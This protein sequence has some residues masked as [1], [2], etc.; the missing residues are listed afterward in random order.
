MKSSLVLFVIAVLLSSSLL[1]Q[2]EANMFNINY[3]FKKATKPAVD[4]VKKVVK[5]NPA[6][7]KAVDIIEE[8]Y[9]KV[10]S[11]EWSLKEK[12]VFCL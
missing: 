12:G 4:A 2:V 9:Q 5:E 7:K 6:V 3:P 1:V 11:K 8:A 10:N